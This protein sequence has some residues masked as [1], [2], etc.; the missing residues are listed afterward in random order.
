MRI[1]ATD[2]QIFNLINAT[3]LNYRERYVLAPIV[4]GVPNLNK[5]R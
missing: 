5:K 1:R 3:P 4:S 2:I